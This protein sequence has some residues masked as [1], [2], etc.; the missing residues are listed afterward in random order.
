MRVTF[1]LNHV[2]LNGGIRVVAIYA[3]QLKKRGHEVVVVARP[4]PVPSLKDR[5][6]SVVKG[7]GWPINPNTLP[8]HFDNVDVDLRVIESRRPIEDRDVPDADVVIATWWETAEWVN[9]L[10]PA[11]G[12]KAYFVQD[13]GA[14]EGQ[15]IDKLAETWRLPMHQIVISHYIRDLVDEQ[16]P[17]TGAAMSYVPNSVDLEQFRSPPRGKQPTP[18]VGTIFSQ[19]RF[20]GADIAIAAC[21]IARK[22]LP[23]LKLIGFGLHDKSRDQPLPDWMTFRSRIPDAELKHIYAGCDAWLFP[24]RK[25]GYGLPILEAMACR[26]PVI[27]TPA[28]AAP[29]LIARGGGF[30]VPHE[31]PASM[32]RQIVQV[33]SLADSEWRRLS[34]SAFATVTGYS[35]ADATNRFEAALGRAIEQSH[36]A[37]A[38]PPASPA[39][40]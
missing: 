9:G 6:K 32:A 28:G 31:D 37:K 40:V 14:N 30:I 20:K 21:E 8:D 19:S 12:A 29:E 38:T 36:S 34:D 5:V 3:E 27:A 4:R 17:G 2:N 25:E 15:P 1:V 10:S 22:K 16:V 11:K 23:D 24:P 39:I 35:W 26:T 13:F 33:C 18:V 7:K